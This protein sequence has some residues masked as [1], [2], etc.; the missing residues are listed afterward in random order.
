MMAISEGLSLSQKLHET[1][2]D[3]IAHTEAGEKLPSEPKLAR[4][5]GVSRATLREAMRTFETQGLISRR[6]GA[7]TFVLRPSSVLDT[8]LEVLESIE[9]LAE[10]TGLQVSLGE[11]Q[12]VQREASEPEATVLRLRPGDEVV[13]ISRVILTEDRPVAFLIDVL[14]RRPRMSPAR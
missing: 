9:T 1:L 7:G 5:L 12:K 3:L 14:R 6:Q 2:G 4:K 11:L 13:D 10:R 8:G